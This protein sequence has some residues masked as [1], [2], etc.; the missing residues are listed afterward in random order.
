MKSAR[1]ALRVLLLTCLGAVVLTLASG[2]TRFTS[3]EGETDAALRLLV[4][5]QVVEPVHGLLLLVAALL[6]ALGSADRGLGLATAMLGA[7]LVLALLAGVATVCFWMP[8]PIATGQQ[9]DYLLSTGGSIALCALAAWIAVGPWSSQPVAD[10]AGE[11][12]D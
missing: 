2:A 1:R 9:I 6:V 5:I 10:P 8:D 11:A 7:V 3:F 12:P 4:S